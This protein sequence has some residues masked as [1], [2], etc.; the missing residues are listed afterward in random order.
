MLAV[1]LAVV[2][3]VILF[4]F[5]NWS[6]HLIWPFAL[7][8]ALFFLY[9]ADK[10]Q[11][12]LGNWRIPELTLHTFALLGGFTG[13]WAGMIVFRHKVRKPVFWMVLIISTLIYG[14]VLLWL[15]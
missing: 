14:V 1:L 8:A 3:F 12:K 6:L 15:W 5:T 10:T 9:G 11:A 2:L 13:G 4:L 7:G